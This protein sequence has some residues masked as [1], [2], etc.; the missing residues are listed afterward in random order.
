MQIICPNCGSK[1]PIEA[2]SLVTQT[3]IV[4]ARCAV[5]FA[6]ELSDEPASAPSHGTGERGIELFQA[7]EAATV[8]RPLSAPVTAVAAPAEVVPSE[9]EVATSEVLLS[10]AARSEVIAP[11]IE[12]VPA[13]EPAIEPAAEISH[14]TLTAAEVSPEA[15]V[16]VAPSAEVAETAESAA[17]RPAAPTIRDVY[18]ILS[19]PEE[20]LLPN[21]S[22]A[23]SALAAAVDHSN[24]LE[25]V[26]AAW[27][28]SRAPKPETDTAE[29]VSNR[30][31]DEYV[32]SPLDPGYAS[33]LNE[34]R[35]PQL[36]TT[37][38]Q[39]AEVAEASADET[40]APAEDAAPES[41]AAS[42]DDRH[43]RSDDR[44]DPARDG[45]AAA[46]VPP[47]VAA[48]Q[49]FDGYGLGVRLMRVS[50]LWLLVSGLSFISFVIFCNWFFLPSNFA[51]ADST[52][53]PASLGNAATNRSFASAPSA[54]DAP[55][56]QT[57]A[58]GDDADRASLPAGAEVVSASVKVEEPTP[59]PTAAAAATP[60]PTPEQKATPAPPQPKPSETAAQAAGK[61]TV[62]VGSYSTPAEA[63]ARAA[64]LRSAG[65][66]VRVAGVEIPKRGKWYRVYVGGF[67]SRADAETHGRLLRERGL[68][69]SFIAAE[70]Q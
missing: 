57:K 53:P 5:E 31:A 41:V 64:R 63:E 10:E 27:N 56:R 8:F 19:L 43:E 38:N 42:S 52:P 69:E 33:A 55:A 49:T 48:A 24:V 67:G 59:A 45:F 28:Q 51:L 58:R 17:A 4:C 62:Q 1:S 18:E 61:F 60:E 11:T 32:T 50:P 36:E 29:A 16:E 47:Q 70:S 46:H 66:T 65:Q 68:A 34:E 9:I 12:I 54:A 14:E 44:H 20:A 6:A 21:E 39:P 13:D 2:G 30:A 26:F 23:D 3:R 15:A 35:A 7:A 22:L 25:D 40:P 37:E